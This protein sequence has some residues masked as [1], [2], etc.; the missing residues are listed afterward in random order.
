MNTKLN[1]YLQ[2]MKLG[3]YPFSLYQ[4]H[5]VSATPYQLFTIYPKERKLTFKYE[6]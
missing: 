1:E 2:G 3:C 5:M 6:C 4:E